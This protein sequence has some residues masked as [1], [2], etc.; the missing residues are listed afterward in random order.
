[1]TSSHHE[2][3]NIDHMLCNLKEPLKHEMLCNL[4]E[5]LKHEVELKHLC[6]S[7]AFQ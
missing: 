2:I 4:K 3:L 7:P 6:M 5:P 1:M